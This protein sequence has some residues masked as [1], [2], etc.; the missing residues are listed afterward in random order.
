MSRH[1][2]PMARRWQS[3][4]PS[5]WVRFSLTR[6]PSEACVF[7]GPT[8]QWWVANGLWLYEGLSEVLGA[9]VSWGVPDWI[10]RLYLGSLLGNRD[11]AVAIAVGGVVYVGFCLWEIRMSPR[12]HL[13]LYGI[14]QHQWGQVHR[15]GGYRPMVFMDHGLMVSFWMAVSTLIA[16]WLGYARS[17]AR[18]GPVPVGAAFM[19]LLATTVLCKSAGALAL[20]LLGGGALFL[21]T[22]S[23]WRWVLVGLALLP[24]VYGV[25]RVSGAFKGEQLVAV[26]AA[27]SDERAASLDFRLKSEKLLIERALE[28]PILGWGGYSRSAVLDPDTDKYLAVQDGLWIAVLGEGGFVRLIFYLLLGALPVLLAL[29]AIGQ[30]PISSPGLAPLAVLAVV[31]ALYTVDCLFNAMIN[32]VYMLIAGSITTVALRRRESLR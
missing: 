26:A 23:A 29:G 6:A 10:G 21:S 32:P 27:V 17:V 31:L 25:G 11:L 7:P 15:L 19:A 1:F 22:A 5:C 13:Q 18:L 8:F 20:L 16:G 9:V 12:L 2:R 24:A 30:G 3:S 14:R 28:Q 4:S